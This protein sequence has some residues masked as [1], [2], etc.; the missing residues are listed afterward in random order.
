M[1]CPKCHGK[2][3]YEAYMGGMSDHDPV[4]VRCPCQT[5]TVPPVAPPESKPDAD[6]AATL[7]ARSGAAYAQ[8]DDARAIR[9]RNAADI[10]EGKVHGPYSLEPSG[11]VAS[12]S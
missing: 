2:G 8:G 6:L 5:A 10:I 7:R 11:E 3:S 9:L 12:E 1:T 4:K